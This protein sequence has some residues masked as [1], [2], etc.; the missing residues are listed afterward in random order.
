MRHGA[1]LLLALF[2][3]LG[4][5]G[6][7]ACGPGEGTQAEKPAEKAPDPAVQA[8]LE[9][10]AS[11]DTARVKSADAEPQNWLSYGRTYDEQRFSPLDQIN[12]S[13]VQELGLAFATD[14]LTDRGVEA[15]PIVVDGVM[16]LSGPWSVVWAL[17]AAS[18]EELWFYDPKVP[19]AYGQKA[20]CDVVNR[21]VAVYGG[22]V[23]VGTLDGYLVALDA[24]T[25]KEAWRVDTLIDRTQPYTITGAPR[26]VDGRVFIGN[27]GAE[28]GVRGYFSAYD[29]NDGNLLWRFFTV[30]GDPAK[31]F[32]SPALEAAAKTWTGEWWKIGGGGTVWDSLVYDAELDLLY[33]GVG[34][35]S[36][37]NRKLRSPEGGDNLY[38]S[39][40]L[41]V[42]PQDGTLVWHYQTT[43][44]DNWDYTATQPMMLADLVI[45]GEPRKVLMQAP[46]NGFFYVLDRVTGELISA[47]KYILA[48]WASH[49]DMLSGRPV[50]TGLADYMGAPALVMPGAPGGH[51]WQ[52]MAFSPQ[53]GLVYFTA[54]DL[55]GLYENDVDFVYKPGAWNTGT[56]FAH[57]TDVPPESLAGRLLAWDPA[58]GRPKWAV[59]HWG[60]WNAGILATAG[61]LVF[62]GTGDGFVRAFK[63]DDGALLWQAPAGTGVIA[64]PVTY[65]VGTEQY[66]AVAAGWGGAFP[67]FAGRAAK[68]AGV[69]SVGRLLAFKLGA[70]GRLPPP[71]AL[72]PPPE[73]PPL[74]EASA[75][76]ILKGRTLY[77]TYCGVCHGFGAVGGGV[78][79]DL[80]HAAPQTHAQW[81]E[82]V[83]GGIRA[84][85]GMASFAQWVSEADANLIHAYVIKRAHEGD[86]PPPD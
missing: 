56:T 16:F 65:S 13:N 62:E 53:T 47:D 84:D 27:G 44:A 70:T 83:R 20:C 52:P 6:P 81:Q 31:G 49:V 35:G 60:P 37:W 21:G 67:L 79:P 80:R 76:D 43:P 66:V 23:V 45:H 71:D 28:Y 38:L 8:R 82:I 68:A 57:T 77:N 26:I 2:L 64:P 18:G 51:N 9:K 32:E 1:R 7:G 4:A 5:A 15:T 25:G 10:A 59:E 17:D 46:K 72:P 12:A 75:E 73:P 29:V 61:G 11:V 78:V 24:K 22:K 63:A 50:E 74:M 39:S 42:K 14:L 36:P 19:K 3:S 54:M 85:G 30:P 58:R 41:A 55:P 33:V 40:I 34:N 48:T 86:V 69:T